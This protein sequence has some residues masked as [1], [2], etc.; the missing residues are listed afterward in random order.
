VLPWTFFCWTNLRVRLP[1]VQGR[2]RRQ[3]R[4]RWQRRWAS[5]CLRI[6][7]F[8]L[9]IDGTPPEPPFLLVSNHVSYVDILLIGSQV[10]G[11]FLSKSEVGDWPVVGELLKTAGTLLITRQSKRQLP[12]VIEKIEGVLAEE[13]G[14]VVFPEGTT[15]NGAE[16]HRFGASLLEPAAR[17]EIP[18][19]YATLTYRTP[20]GVIPATESVCWYGNM[21]FGPHVLRLLGLPYVEAQLEFGPERIVERERKMLAR[22]LQEAVTARFRPVTGCGGEAEQVTWV[23]S[24]K[25][26][27]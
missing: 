25:G 6:M 20:D 7:G 24:V 21:D 27:A 23:D 2:S 4:S 18:V 26:R 5:N 3:L 10:D 12:E 17:D 16:V 13:S 14:V 22:R 15:F 1:F 9:N 19:A 11:T 8:R